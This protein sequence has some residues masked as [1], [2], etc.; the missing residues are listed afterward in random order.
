M[1]L[2][3]QFRFTVELDWLRALIQLTPQKLLSY[4]Q[5]DRIYSYL[6][7]PFS[8]KQR[9]TLRNDFILLLDSTEELFMSFMDSLGQLIINDNYQGA[10]GCSKVN[11]KYC[12]A[13]SDGKISHAP[14]EIFHLLMIVCSIFFFLLQMTPN[15]IQHPERYTRVIRLWIYSM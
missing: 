8:Q 3:A 2:L 6:H 7:L 12:Y 9:E 5:S 4:I 15:R 11:G 13:E 1:D 10:H 14:P